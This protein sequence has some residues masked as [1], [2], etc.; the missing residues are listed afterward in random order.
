MT[1]FLES[2]FGANWRTTL[3][4]I[5]GAALAA[6]KEGAYSDPADWRKWI[7]PVTIAVLGYLSKDRN[8]T[9]GSVVQNRFGKV[10]SKTGVVI[11]AA[12]LLPAMLLGT[13]ACTS[14]GTTETAVT[15]VSQDAL[16]ALEDFAWQ[17]ALKWLQRKSGPSTV[18]SAIASTD[19]KAATKFPTIPA[20]TRQAEVKK[21]FDKARQRH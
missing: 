3:L 4:G 18:D 13:V 12:I 2:I 1:N 20:A 9:G 17:E 10:V 11:A 21:A 19:A 14:T 5:I 7:I 8:V 15:T 6:Y 16:K